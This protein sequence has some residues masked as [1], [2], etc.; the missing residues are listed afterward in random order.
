MCATQLANVGMYAS[1]KW[2]GARSYPP[3]EIV[4][5]RF[6][7]TTLF[8]LVVVHAWHGRAIPRLHRI[9][10]HILRNLFLLGS[11]GFSFA[12]LRYLKLADVQAVLYLSPF[13]TTAAAV[14]FL[15]EPLR[16][17]VIPGIAAAFA[18]ESQLTN[19]NRSFGQG[20]AGYARYLGTS[21]AD[22]VIGDYMTEIN[23]TSP[24]G[25]RAIKRLGGPDL[26][27]AIWDAIE[28]KLRL[29]SALSFTEMETTLEESGIHLSP[30]HRN[31]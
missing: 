7:F 27:V 5:T 9:G 12:A 10:T 17:R 28:A 6:L 18:G 2:V 3:M 22:F 13:V 15:R 19:A 23:V 8:A 20:V 30:G 31:P 14:F 4:A 11:N 26:A 21:Y 25:I 16:P 29:G 24:T 1:A